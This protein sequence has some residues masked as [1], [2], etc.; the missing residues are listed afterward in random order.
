M[1]TQVP[2]APLHWSGFL[3]SGMRKE[4]MGLGQSCPFPGRR[5]LGL[6]T[7]R[8]PALNW[9]LVSPSS[10]WCCGGS[11]LRASEVCSSLLC[12]L[13]RIQLSSVRSQS[14]SLHCRERVPSS[15]GRVNARGG[16]GWPRWA[17]PKP[18]LKGKSCQPMRGE[19]PAP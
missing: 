9:S 17:G 19:L 1:K 2:Q 6:F 4:L 18:S 3:K 13:L 16:R 14:P 11:R 8:V 10:P 7:G 5:H 12:L 15:S